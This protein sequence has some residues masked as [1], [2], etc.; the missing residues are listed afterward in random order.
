[1]LQ[2]PYRTLSTH[3]PNTKKKQTIYIFFFIFQNQKVCPEE[4]WDTFMKT[5]KENLPTAF[6]IT[7]SKCEAAALMK[8][9]QSQYFSEILNMKLQVEGEGEQGEEIKPINLPW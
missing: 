1:M 8:I 5:L 6:R 4:E 2:D 9:V 3:W 7:G